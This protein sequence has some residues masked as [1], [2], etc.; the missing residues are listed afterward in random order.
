MAVDF[1][2]VNLIGTGS[3]L[4]GAEKVGMRRIVAFSTGPFLEVHRHD[5][6]TDGASGDL[7]A[8]SRTYL[9]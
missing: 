8:R 5:F 9:N 7:A 1:E 6:A 4:D 3:L 2:A